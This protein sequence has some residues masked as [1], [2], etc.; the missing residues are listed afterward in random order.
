MFSPD[1]EKFFSDSEH[2]EKNEKDGNYLVPGFLSMVDV[3]PIF[4]STII[5]TECDL[6]LT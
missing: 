1:L 6:V 5:L 4:F 3:N 2:F